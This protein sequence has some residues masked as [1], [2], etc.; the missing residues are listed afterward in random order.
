MR[1]SK[2]EAMGIFRGFFAGDAIAVLQV[3]CGTGLDAR[4]QE[5]H[6]PLVLLNTGRV[7]GATR[8]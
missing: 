1:M 8:S 2:D 5:I 4:D 6:G 3:K 7:F